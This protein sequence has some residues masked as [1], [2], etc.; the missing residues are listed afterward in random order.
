MKK[1][2]EFYKSFEEWK[3]KSFSDTKK[4]LDIEQFVINNYSL[5]RHFHVGTDS[6]SYSDHT[7]FATALVAHDKHLGGK[8]A[9]H[10]EKYTSVFSSLRQRLIIEAMKTL[11]VAWYL[12]QILPSDGK[13]RLHL[14]V[15]NEIKFKS[16]S[17]KEELVGMIMGQGYVSYRETKDDKHPRIV[18]WKPDSWAAQSVAD[19]HT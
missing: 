2:Q 19:R 17:Y 15:N 13:I 9:I 5:G 8:I 3:W 4:S 1:N 12:D 7:L 14:D 6:Q 18:F 16:G 11:E 10:K